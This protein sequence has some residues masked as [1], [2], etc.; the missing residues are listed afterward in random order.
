MST[1]LVFQ[2]AAPPPPTFFTHPHC[3]LYCVTVDRG[4]KVDYV[5]VDRGLKVNCVTV[6]RGLKVDCV[7]VD[8]GLQG[9]LCDI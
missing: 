9:R 7:R 8:R 2:L 4:L 1:Q 3:I 5:T 6:D